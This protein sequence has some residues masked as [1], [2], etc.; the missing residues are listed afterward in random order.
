M[1]HVRFRCA[2]CGSLLSRPVV[3][4][5]L[6]APPELESLSHG[7]NPPLLPAGTYAVDEAEFGI[8]RLRGTFVLSPG[9]VRGTTYVYGRCVDG[10]WSLNGWRGPNMAC[11]DCGAMV[12]ARTDDCYRA[13]ETRLDPDAVVAEG[14]DPATADL[15]GECLA[16]PE[17]DLFSWEPAWCGG[18]H[19]RDGERGCIPQQCGLRLSTG[20][21]KAHQP[22][23]VRTHWRAR[24]LAAEVYRDDPPC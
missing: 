21:P 6:P 13:Q 18:L 1:D 15:G 9:D 22:R 19:D 3:R 7:L 8:G 17:L 10:C 5:P 16:D 2:G 14:F 4:V 20:C 24:G 12:A 11:A 23:L